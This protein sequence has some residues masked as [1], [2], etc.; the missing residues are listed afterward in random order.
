MNS[1]IGMEFHFY[2]MNDSEKGWWGWLQNKVNV[3]RCATEHLKMVNI[4]MHIL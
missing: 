2:K 1:L 4:V 3:F